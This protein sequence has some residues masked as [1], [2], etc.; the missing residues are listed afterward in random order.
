MLRLPSHRGLSGPARRPAGSPRPDAPL[1]PALHGSWE[2]ESSLHPVR[3]ASCDDLSPIQRGEALLVRSSLP[4]T[5]PRPHVQVT[6]TYPDFYMTRRLV[7]MALHVLQARHHLE[8]ETLVWAPIT[9]RAPRR[10]ATP[11]SLVILC[12]ACTWRCKSGAAHGSFW[13]F[14][15]TARSQD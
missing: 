1:I 7:W 9:D 13:H 2:P 3:N 8:R 10:A 12:G 14:S 11:V 15:D 4:L 6:P 5:K